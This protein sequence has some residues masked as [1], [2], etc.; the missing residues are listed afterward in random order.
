[1]T[2]VMW[3][4]ADWP[5]PD[6]VV[7]GCS[8]RRCGVSEGRYASLNI[9]DRVDDDP[10][11]VTTNRERLASVCGLSKEPVWLRQVHG[12][13]VATDPAAGME[14]DA[15]LTGERLV[16]C[17]VMVAD[18]LPVLFCR[19]NGSQVAAAHAGWRG[20]ASGVL[21]ATLDAFSGSPK[22]L[23]AWLG[24][25][26]SQSAFEVGD[27]VR[28]AFLKSDGCA[29]DHFI[30]NDRGR[31]QADLPGLARQRL[32]AA[33][34]ERVFGGEHCTYSDSESF[35]SHRRDGVCGRMAAF[36]FRR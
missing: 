2:S 13:R 23:M 32:A 14:A 18:C 12:S 36:I 26:I 27:D 6:S 35:F 3:I 7:A 29:A 22:S 20:L 8:T 4:P 19:D 33:G 5:A 31:W 30:R 9:C 10:A 17:A 11:A 34:V 28:E 15:S 25:A 21:E 16:V 1:M 24:P